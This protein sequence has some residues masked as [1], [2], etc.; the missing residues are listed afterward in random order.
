V[1]PA[2]NPKGKNKRLWMRYGRK[3]QGKRDVR[4]PKDRSRRGLAA[5]LTE[6]SMRARASLQ[7]RKHSRREGCVRGGPVKQTGRGPM[8][9]TV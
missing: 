7:K 5:G 2:K 3:Q 6:K 1:R 9:E 8:P 4:G